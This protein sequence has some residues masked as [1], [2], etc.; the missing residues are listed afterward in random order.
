MQTRL[1]KL[2]NT[3]FVT[4]ACTIAAANVHASIY[5]FTYTGVFTVQASNGDLLQNTDATTNTYSGFRTNISGNY[6]I[7]TAQPQG[8]ASGVFNII[9]FDFFGGDPLS[10]AGGSS[11]NIGDGSGGPG[12]LMLGNFTFDWKEYKGEYKEI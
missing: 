7:G 11:T 4:I 2:I 3:C 5:N 9:P 10:F 12:N 6:S 8:T 1:S